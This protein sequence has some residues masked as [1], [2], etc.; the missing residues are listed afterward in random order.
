MHSLALIIALATP[1]P[2]EALIVQAPKATLH[3]EIASTEPQREQG[4]MNRTHLDPHTGML[5]VFPTDQPVN[6]WMKNTLI[7]LDMIFIDSN[8]KVRQVI[9]NV[10][11]VSPTLPDNQI[12]LEQSSGKYV[13]ELPAGEAGK[14]GIIPGVTIGNVAKAPA[15]T[16]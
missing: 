4:L 7:S 8:G 16:L 14:D 2:Q 5:F 13:I 10:P 1:K 9:A 3:L 6:F 12:P 11:T 15:A